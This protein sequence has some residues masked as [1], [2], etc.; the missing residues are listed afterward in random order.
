MTLVIRIS[1]HP[2]S[3]KT[4]LARNLAKLLGFQF[5]YTG[6][7]FRE[8]AEKYKKSLEDFYREMK[9]NPD[10]EKAIDALQAKLMNE[11]NNL[12]VDGR[13]A[14]FQPCDFTAVN[15]LLTVSDEEGAKRLA[16]RPE[17]KNIR[18]S[19]IKQRAKKRVREERTRYQKLYGIDDHL[20]KKYFDVVINTTK[21][22]PDFILFYAAKEIQG[23]LNKT[24]I[25]PLKSA[26]L[27]LPRT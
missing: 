8:M 4:T 18:R 10:L 9:K 11:G 13:I 17:N 7:I 22:K 1:G 14:P 2:G 15:V 21:Y 6:G 25:K 19:K 16:L 26:S 5:S 3:G 20:A 27:D 12:V 23:A 24:K